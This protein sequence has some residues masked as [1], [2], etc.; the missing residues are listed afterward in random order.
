MN[1]THYNNQQSNL[2]ETYQIPLLEEK[3]Q[4]SRHK[5]K[6]GEVIV[7]KQVE[8][9]TIEVPIKREKLIVERIGKDP[10]QLIEVIIGEDKVNGFKYGELKDRDSLHITKSQFLEV[11]TARKLLEAIANLSSA[12]NAKVRLEIVTNLAEHQIESQN[13]CDLYQ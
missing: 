9:R 6:V 5:K 7:R 8:T 3:L 12:N 4:I 11:Q 10:E 2:P 13:L 1:P